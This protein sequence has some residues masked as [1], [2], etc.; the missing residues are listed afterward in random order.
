MLDYLI[1]AVVVASFLGFGAWAVAVFA[2]VFNW[3]LSQLITQ[4]RVKAATWPLR[5]SCLGLVV[6]MVPAEPL[7]LIGMIVV[8]LALSAILLHVL[9]QAYADHAYAS[10]YASAYAHQPRMKANA[11]Q[12]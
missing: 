7:V 11:L 12:Q 8:L 9:E 3:K 6:V 1:L 2:L 5:L 10:V 4:L